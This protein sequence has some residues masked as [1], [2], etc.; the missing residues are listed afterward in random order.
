MK[1]ALTICAALTLALPFPAA[2][3]CKLA[4]ALGIDISSS[5]DPTEYRLQLDGLADALESE[6]VI[7]A[8][9]QPEGAWIAVAAYEWSGYPQQDVIA[10]WAELRSVQDVYR[11]ANR[12]RAHPRPYWDFAT[13]IGVSLEYGAQLMA[14]APTCARR[15][16]DLSGDGVNNNGPE[17]AHFY[18]LGLLD[19]ITVN[20]LVIRG[21]DPDPVPYYQSH[22]IFG[23]EA[24]IA[25]AD[26][27]H[28][29]RRAMQGKLIREISTEMILGKR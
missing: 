23:P 1:R 8:I 2:A 22:V 5:V 20:G 7:E 14:R 28:D 10:E 26:D 3:T 27:F 6:G 16:I 9:F 25:V 29:Y 11:F 15:V 4:L 13:A 24:F 21:A 19:G 12:L 17:P 18:S